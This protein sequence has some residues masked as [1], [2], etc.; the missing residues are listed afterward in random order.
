MTYPHLKWMNS[1]TDD[2][3]GDPCS[4]DERVLSSKNVKSEIIEN[5]DNDLQASDLC[6]VSPRSE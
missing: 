2:L 4:A 3:Q 6:D 1:E 5:E